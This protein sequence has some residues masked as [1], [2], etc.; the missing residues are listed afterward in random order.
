MK[1]GDAT[2]GDATRQ[3]VLAI[4]DTAID[5]SNRYKLPPDTLAVDVVRVDKWDARIGCVSELGK[6]G[7][8]G[9]QRENIN[10]LPHVSASWRSPG[11]VANRLLQADRRCAYGFRLPASPGNLMG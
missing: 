5:H 11:V 8:S 1:K 2:R 10:N 9:Y 3:T 4:V 6:H 7:Q